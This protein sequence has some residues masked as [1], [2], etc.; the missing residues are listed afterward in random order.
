MLSQKNDVDWLVVSS[1]SIIINSL[2]KD[3]KD[4]YY[5]SIRRYLSASYN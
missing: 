3:K 1:T 4:K 5:S 2:Q